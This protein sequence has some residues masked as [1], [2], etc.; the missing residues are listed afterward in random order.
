MILEKMNSHLI[1]AQ[2][3]IVCCVNFLHKMEETNIY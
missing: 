1:Q 3:D 2:S